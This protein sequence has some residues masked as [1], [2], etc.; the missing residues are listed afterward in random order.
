[1]EGETGVHVPPLVLANLPCREV[2][3]LELTK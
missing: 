3:D 1:M 2:S